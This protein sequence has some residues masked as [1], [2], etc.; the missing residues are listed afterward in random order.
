MGPDVSEKDILLLA[1]TM[2][3]KFGFL[4][5][6]MGGAKAG[7]S[8]RPSCTEEER[9]QILYT[10][11]QRLKP[12]IWKGIYLPGEDIGTDFSDI[13]LIEKGAGFRQNPD[14]SDGYQGSGYYTGLA[15][16]TAAKAMAQFAGMETSQCSVMIEGFGKVGQGIAQELLREKASVVGISTKLGGAYQPSGF[17]LQTLLKKGATMGDSLIENLSHAKAISLEDLV[18]S[19]V[20]ILFLCGKPWPITLENA[21]RIK[22]KIVVGAGNLCFSN[23]LEEIVHRMGIIHLPDVATS[24]GGVLAGNLRMIG[25]NH[26]NIEKVIRE[27]YSQKIQRL[28]RHVNS[29]G[30][31]PTDIIN[32]IAWK[33]FLGMKVGGLQGKKHQMS[34]LLQKVSEKGLKYVLA[35][36]TM[37][38]F[39]LTSLQRRMFQSLL[40]TYAQESLRSE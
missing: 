5:I 6:P 40:L 10:F 34:N 11:G 16:V 26:A 33:N 7:I 23:G 18:T 29:R 32:K 24:C 8:I 31:N 17:D 2:T 9:R 35:C 21:G 4:K 15:A 30:S 19:E 22:A 14:S 39:P 36:L 13:Q 38:Y 20:D 25:L 3:L 12:L 27:E 37:N 1:R 28:L